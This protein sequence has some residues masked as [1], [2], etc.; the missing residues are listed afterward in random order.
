M[1]DDSTPFEKAAAARAHA[2]GSSKNVGQTTCCVHPTP[3]D[4][5]NECKALLAKFQKEAATL[6]DDQGDPIKNGSQVNRRITAAYSKMYQPRPDLYWAGAA[7]FVSKQMGCNMRWADASSDPGWF[8]RAA[9]SLDGHDVKA[10]AL[11]SK[12]VLVRANQAIFKDIYPQ[13]RLYEEKPQC[14]TVYGNAL[15]LDKRMIRGFQAYAAG[16]RY[17]GMM[18]HADYEQNVVLQNDVM[19]N[20][21]LSKDVQNF[22]EA[23][24]ANR[25]RK[26]R[27]TGQSQPEQASFT[28]ECVASG[29]KGSPFY[30]QP[31]SGQFTDKD[32]RWNVAVP[33]LDKYNQ[34]MQEHPN[35]MSRAIIDIGQDMGSNKLPTY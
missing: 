2:V 18:K 21:E 27:W 10:L 31:P 8:K 29:G 20:P 28:R 33:T 34:L 17:R 32:Q 3:P 16:D 35:E 7:T 14:A 15:G 30:F 25:E 6:A 1:S 4:P 26:V 22:Q 5:A 13:Y 12:K 19:D 9:G 11:S 24:N 23:Q